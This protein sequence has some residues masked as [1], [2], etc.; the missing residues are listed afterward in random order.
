MSETTLS[1]LVVILAVVVAAP[2]L[3]DALA[4]R[5]SVPTVVIEIGLGIVIGPVLHWASDDDVISF[6]GA[7]GLATLMFLAGLEIDLPRIRGR[8]MR[9]AGGGWLVSLVLGV[10]LGVALVPIDGARSGLIVGL[11]VTTTALGVLLP[12]LRDSG[13]LEDDF[14]TE[15]LA[16]A[17]AGEL[18]PLIAIALLLSTDRPARTVLVLLVFVAIAAAAA[19]AA[20]RP[21]GE[22]LGRLLN[23]TLTTSG[24]FAIRLVVLFLGAMVW[25]ADELGLDI[26]LGAFAAGMVFRLFSAGASDREAELV[27]AKLHGL[28][29]GFFIPVFFVVSGMRFDVDA[30]VDDP[31]ILLAVP[32]FALAF[33]LVRGGPTFVIQRRWPTRDRLAMACYLSTQ[34]PLVVVITGIG[35]E[36]GRL[37]SGTAAAAVGAAMISVLVFPLLANR[38]HH[39]TVP[40]PVDPVVD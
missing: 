35:V 33:L 30:F 22:R 21:R 9:R 39:P 26:I 25:V 23:T 24:Q 13:D 18:L 3:S 31:V 8:P 34:L 10:A 19:F 14:G 12:I 7:F 37:K 5:V 29:F 20:T 40:S 16:G 1:S 2:A 15:V 4:R 27:E 6:L 11:A 38:L 17:A 36:T 32:G 28:G